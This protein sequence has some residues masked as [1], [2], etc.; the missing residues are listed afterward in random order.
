LL[1]R[2]LQTALPATIKIIG[3]GDI[4]TGT[5]YPSARYLPPNGGRDLL[6]PVHS[7]LQSADI[8]FGNLEGTVLNSGGNAKRCS[9]PSKCYVF[10]M[11]ESHVDHLV[12][13]GFDIVSIANNHSGDMGPAGR[14]NTIR[15]LTENGIA[16]AG[17][18]YA[19]RGYL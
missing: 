6:K 9:D 18:V 10:R 5:N 16:C 1:Q 4:M 7:V 11:P 15:M 12:N 17:L 19:S 2:R 14:T 8:T 3:V 13:A